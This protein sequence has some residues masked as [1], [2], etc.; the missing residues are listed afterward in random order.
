MNRKPS[1]SSVIHFSSAFGGST[2]WAERVKAKRTVARGAR[3]RSMP[4]WY[5]GGKAAFHPSI[6]R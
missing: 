3:R 4:G 5:Y 6:Q 1:V 2:S